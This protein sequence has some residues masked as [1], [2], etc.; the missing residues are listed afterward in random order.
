ESRVGDLVGDRRGTANLR[1]VTYPLEQPV[2]DAWGTPRSN[3][4]RAGSVVGEVDTEYCRRATDDLLH[5]GIVV[6]VEPQYRAEAVTQWSG[7]ERESGGGPDEREARQVDPHRP[8]RRPLADH[9]VD[10]VILHRR[11]QHLFDDAVEAMDLIDEEHVPL[12][13]VGEDRDE[14]ALTLDRGPR[15]HAQVHPHLGG[16]DRREGGLAQSR[17]AVEKDVVEG[18]LASSSR[19]DEDAE[20]VLHP[21]LSDV[22][23]Q[24]SWPQRSIEPGV[25]VPVLPAH[26]AGS[27]GIVGR[28]VYQPLLQQAATSF[29]AAVRCSKYTAIRT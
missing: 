27:V 7:H 17:R 23:V 24:A 3:R 15:R 11:V 2:G 13:Q 9:D 19:L 8:G 6:V 14:I 18:L 1:D 21:V 28:H 4:E 22:L 25:L 16:N 26:H 29:A 10:R 5:G 12:F 20:I